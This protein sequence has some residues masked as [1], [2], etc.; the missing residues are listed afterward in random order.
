MNVR[1]L[2][3][4]NLL[5]YPHDNSEP[6][7]QRLAARVLEELLQTGAGCVSTQVLAEFYSVLT[8]KLRPRV[9][10]ADAVASLHRHARLWTVFPVTV[11]AILHAAWGAS[12]FQMSFWDAQL[13]AVARL[14][15]LAFI[16]TE[17]FQDGAV[18]GGVR[19]VNPLLPGWTSARL[20]V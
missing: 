8:T 5:V 19:Y 13:W 16:L 20:L 12:E 11:E 6:R 15:R 2:V 3:D 17:D 7:K 9:T 14:N 18:I 4:T 1:L 10:V